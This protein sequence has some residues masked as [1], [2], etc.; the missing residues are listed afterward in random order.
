MLR[1]MKMCPK[2]TACCFCRGRWLTFWLVLTVAQGKDSPLSTRK[3]N[4][5]AAV[6][7]TKAD[8]G[9]IDNIKFPSECSSR[10]ITKRSSSFGT[11]KFRGLESQETNCQIFPVTTPSPRTTK[12]RTTTQNP[13]K[14]T[15]HVGAVVPGRRPWFFPF[16]PYYWR[17]HTHTFWN[18]LLPCNRG[19][20]SRNTIC[21]DKSQSDESSEEKRGK[22]RQSPKIQRRSKE[23]LED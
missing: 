2:Q 21:S 8:D 23:S 13:R 1:G 14:P 10:K 20:W 3:G 18:P 22:R 5:D 12:P 15:H 19:T 17:P 9:L 7:F 16:V 6:E 4:Q 11:L